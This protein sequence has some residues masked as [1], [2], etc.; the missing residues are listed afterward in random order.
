M[1]GRRKNGETARP[2]RLL[3]KSKLCE[4]L[5][6]PDLFHSYVQH[7]KVVI[8]WI[9]FLFI[10]YSTGARVEYFWPGWLFLCSVNES[11][12]FEGW[13]FAII[14]VLIVVATDLICFF[15]VPI[16]WVFIFGSAY[17][18][19]YLLWHIERGVCLPT[20][21]L[22][23]VFMLFEIE[24]R[25]RELKHFT[26]SISLFRPFAAHCIGYPA[27]CVGFSFKNYFEVKYR[28]RKKLDVRA[29]NEQYYRLLEDALYPK[30]APSK[31]PR[32]LLDDYDEKRAF[33]EI[34]MT[35]ASSCFL[36]GELEYRSSS[37]DSSLAAI[38]FY[39]FTCPSGNLFDSEHVIWRLMSRL[40]HLPL[41]R[42][43][44]IFS[45]RSTREVLAG[46]AASE[47][48]VFATCNGHTTQVP[49][50]APAAI[51]TL[52]PSG[53]PSTYSSSAPSYAN[54]FTSSTLV[55]KA[56]MQQKSLNNHRDTDINAK[57]AAETQLQLQL[58]QLDADIGQ[59]SEQCSSKRADNELLSQRI[60]KLAVRNKSDR[61]ALSSI[62]NQI[63][64]ETRNQKEIQEKMRRIAQA[65]NE[66]VVE[67]PPVKASKPLPVIGTFDPACANGLPGPNGILACTCGAQEEST[68]VKK[69]RKLE[70]ELRSLQ[71]QLRQREDRVR[72]LTS[73]GTD[74]C[75]L[76]TANEVE[77]MLRSSREEQQSLAGALNESRENIDELQHHWLKTMKDAD[78]LSRKIKERDSDIFNLNQRVKT[79][80][81]RIEELNSTSSCFFPTKARHNSGAKSPPSFDQSNWKLPFYDSSP[82]KVLLSSPFDSRPMSVDEGGMMGTYYGAGKGMGYQVSGGSSLLSSMLGE[83]P[84]GERDKGA[85]GKPVTRSRWGD[86]HNMW[87]SNGTSVTSASQLYD[88]I[89]TSHRGSQPPTTC[90]N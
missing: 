81:Q 17:V 21:V 84:G 18:W 79:Y 30:V 12:R 43:F 20:C 14:F 57:F 65:V 85:S 40:T 59:N 25:A 63:A 29:K 82:S 80:E 50:K 11:L 69:R 66:R 27:V 23:L 15:L 86:M 68:C 6:S 8:L 47:A 38:L 31:G 35:S 7:T 53:T 26:S 67:S 61:Q 78:E 19:I 28:T 56:S 76:W 87:Q 22:F 74:K 52:R 41:I 51:D 48:D 13:Y 83:E 4:Y 45:R 62:E 54:S 72:H 71:T 16:T 24:F 49:G 42:A 1:Y 5:S 34:K 37:L 60:S 55:D 9:L 88:P 90:S 10:N 46:K 70:Q 75:C 3:K 36:N 89:M 33:N 2:K 64:D 77:T 58:N 44:F 73:K 32:P 39:P